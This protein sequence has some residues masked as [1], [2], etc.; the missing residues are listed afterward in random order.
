MCGR[1]FS[2]KLNMMM[3]VCKKRSK[4]SHLRFKCSFNHHRWIKICHA[5]TGVSVLVLWSLLAFYFLDSKNEIHLPYL[6][7]QLLYCLIFFISILLSSSSIW[8]PPST[9]WLFCHFLGVRIN[10]FDFKWLTVEIDYCFDFKWLTWNWL[11]SSSFNTA[12]EFDFD[13]QLM[14]CHPF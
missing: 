7:V 8:W 3:N 13:W 11:F 1:A 5:L 2:I 9:G 6:Y 14:K 10:C 12:N 4:M